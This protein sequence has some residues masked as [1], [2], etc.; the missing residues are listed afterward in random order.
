MWA[1]KAPG[2]VQVAEAEGMVQAAEGVA[3]VQGAKAAEALKMPKSTFVALLSEPK[4]APSPVALRRSEKNCLL[5]YAS[6]TGWVLETAAAC[7]S[8]NL[9][10]QA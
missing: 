4:P 5:L 9:L 7:D 1:T 6:G 10:L 2:L 3:M 8:M